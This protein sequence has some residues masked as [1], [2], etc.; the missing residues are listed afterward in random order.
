MV[1]F[2]FAIYRIAFLNSFISIFYLNRRKEHQLFLFNIHYFAMMFRYIGIFIVELCWKSQMNT[3]EREK[4]ERR[5]LKNSVEKKSSGK[6]KFDNTVHICCPLCYPQSQ[7]EWE[8]DKKKKIR[9]E[10]G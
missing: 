1:L 3:T 6:W 7:I 9:I 4:A 10:R 8:R 2:L 5:K